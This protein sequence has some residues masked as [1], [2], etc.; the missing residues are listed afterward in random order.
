MAI[1]HSHKLVLP[2]DANHYGTLYAGAMLRWTLEAGYATAWKHVGPEA[3]L[4]LRR[5]LN[6]ECLRPVPV[7]VVAEIQGAVIR[8]TTAYLICGLVGTPWDGGTQWAEAL[9]GFAQVNP[10]GKPTHLPDRLPAVSVP[11]GEVWER[12]E[13]RM[14]KLL[15]LRS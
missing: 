9:F 13:R 3:N 6:M 1:T 12:L 10:D 11:P 15:R 5:V 8:R 4:V 7:G 2:A 14:N